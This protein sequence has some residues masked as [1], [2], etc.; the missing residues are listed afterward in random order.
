MVPIQ[1]TGDELWKRMN[2]AV[3]KIQERL[4]KTARTLENAN[5]PYAIIGG[6]AVRAWVAQKDEAAVRT[7]RDVDILLQREDLP[8]AIEAMEKVGFVYRVVRGIPMFLDGP[9]SKA[10]DAVHVLFASEKVRETDLFQTPSIDQSQRIDS[11][12]FLNLDALVQM[13]LN[14][15]RDKDRMHLRD[16]LDVELIDEQWPNQLPTELGRRLQE[17]IDNPEDGLEG[18]VEEE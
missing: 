7:T 9:D 16:M 3:E 11:H 13:K 12:L 6:N 2:R 15:F 17:L 5:I 8:R 10:R 14:V 18:L 4:E 1:F